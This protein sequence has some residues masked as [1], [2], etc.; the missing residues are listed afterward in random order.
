ML[1]IDVQL[2]IMIAAFALACDMIFCKQFD[3]Y[4][5]IGFEYK[6]WYSFW[7]NLLSSRHGTDIYKVLTKSQLGIALHIVAYTAASVIFELLVIKPLGIVL[8]HGWDI[9]PH[10][11]IGFIFLLIWICVYYRL[12]LRYYTKNMRI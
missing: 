10:S 9:I 1:F 4:H 2:L 8:Y 5:Y 6:G 11:V 7:A 12:M 3:L